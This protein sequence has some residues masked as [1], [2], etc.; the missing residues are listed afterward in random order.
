[1]IY[2]DYAA[3]TPVDATVLKKMLP[4]FTEQFGNASSIHQAGQIAKKAVEKNRQLIAQALECESKEIIFTSGATESNN[5]AIKGVFKGISQNPY[6][7]KLLK[8]PSKGRDSQSQKLHFITSAIEHHCVLDSMK[9]LAEE[10]PDQAEVTF[11][12][13]DQSGQI[14]LEELKK[15]I[16]PNTVLVSIMYVNNE[17]GTIEPLEAVSAVLVEARKERA[18]NA[19]EAGENENTAGFQKPLPLYFHSDAT[20]AFAYL[21][22]NLKKLGL[23]LL[24]MSAHK[25]YGPKGVGLLAAKKHVLLKEIQHG[26]GHENKRRSGTLNVSGIVGLGA[27]VELAD[28]NREQNAA[29]LTRLKKYLIDEIKKEI[30]G[31]QLN[32]T[33]EL[34]APHI[35]N[36]SFPGAEGESIALLLSEKGIMVSTGSACSSETLQASHVQ[37]ALGNNHL[38]AHSSIRFSLGKDTTEKELLEAVQ[39]LKEILAKLREISQGIKV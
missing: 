24:T 6:F 32:G 27:A 3:T 29:K 1:M 11:L 12:K 17:I 5:L 36:F 39:A 35:V 26:G 9:A 33:P 34:T 28:Q 8:N 4:F 23:D 20:Q 25:I 18:K 7:K 19:G 21:P 13:V 31:A 38:R 22:T 15:S 14:N 10:F 30:V 37:L 16:K 2:L